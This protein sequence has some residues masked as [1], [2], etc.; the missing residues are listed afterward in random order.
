MTGMSAFVVFSMMGFYPVT[1]GVP[2]YNLASPVFDRITIRL[3]NGKTLIII[4]RNM[5]LKDLIELN[6]RHNIA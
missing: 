3:H 1:P 4:C 2:V 5:I 6:Q